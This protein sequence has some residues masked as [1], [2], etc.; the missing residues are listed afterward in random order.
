MNK[1]AP[2]WWNTDNYK[3]N[4]FK[5]KTKY[6]APMLVIQDNKL[7]V[8][9]SRV[10]LVTCI[11]WFDTPTLIAIIPSILILIIIYF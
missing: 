7:I 4:N 9:I 1:N 10:S 11:W 6:S 2:R 3:E 8:A 5:E